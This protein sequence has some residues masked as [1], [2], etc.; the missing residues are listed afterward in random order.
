METP[1]SDEYPLVAATAA[2]NFKESMEFLRKNP[3]LVDQTDQYGR[4]ALLV[5]SIVGFQQIV[6]ILLE[7][8]ADINK[9]DFDGQTP[10]MMSIKHQNNVIFLLLFRNGADIN[11]CDSQGMNAL[12]YAALSNEK[13]LIFLC[14]H[15]I[16]TT[17]ADKHGNKPLMFSCMNGG[18]GME[19]ILKNQKALVDHID[20]IDRWGMSELMYL[21]DSGSRRTIKFFLEK[22]SNPNLLDNMGRSPIFRCVMKDKFQIITDLVSYNA[23]PNLGNPIFEAIFRRFPKSLST[24][25]KC[26]ANINVQDEFGFTP[27]AL[28]INIYRMNFDHP[29]NDSLRECIRIL[30]EANPDLNIQNHLGA[31]PLYISSFLEDDDVMSQLLKLGADPNLLNDEGHSP[32]M[33]TI[34]RK[35]FPKT[36]LLLS[37]GAMG[38]TISR[39]GETVQSCV[40][41]T[42]DQRFLNLFSPSLS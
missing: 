15:N 38:N 22:G 29:R 1:P 25:I 32:L 19:I 10:L 23:D 3:K 8:H 30:L 39:F 2:K 40:Q 35:D 12:M 31:S 33:V 16:D 42:K 34:S 37:N 14:R 18:T 9:P 27:I 41:Q 13:I 4:T 6:P 11:L 26:G 24:L 20:H 28:A 17:K 5:A 21:I 36:L 7:Y